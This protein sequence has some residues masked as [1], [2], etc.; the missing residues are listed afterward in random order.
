MNDNELASQYALAS[1]KNRT[2]LDWVHRDVY[3]A[4]IY[5][6]QKAREDSL[7]EIDKWGT[8]AHE[9]YLE[10]VRLQ[11]CNLEHGKTISDLE[12]QLALVQKQNE[13]LRSCVEDFK[14]HGTR[15]SVNPVGVFKDCGCF[16]D[17]G[18][19]NWQKYIR[20]QDESVRERA[21]ET[22]KKLEELE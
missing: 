19:S 13:I 10:M 2:K 4:F 12:S 20:S 16:D 6:Y 3:N 8:I 7:K 18:G 17:M 14:D 21:R 9:R 22:I 1:Q 5:A 15:H 11:N